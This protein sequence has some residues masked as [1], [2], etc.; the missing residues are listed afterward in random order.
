MQGP[1]Q[2]EDH[3]LSLGS[4]SLPGPRYGL[5]S[6]LQLPRSAEGGGGEG[7]PFERGLLPSCGLVPWLPQLPLLQ[8]PAQG[9]T[10]RRKGKRKVEVG[11]RENRSTGRG[12]GMEGG[13]S[14]LK[15]LENGNNNN[16]TGNN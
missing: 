3:G 8:L 2:P 12:V 13:Q 5:V 14:L 11:R 10:G 6:V 1:A 9:S 7:S 15:E 4:L 16:E